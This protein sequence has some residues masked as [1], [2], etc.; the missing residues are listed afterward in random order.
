MNAWNVDYLEEARSDIRSLDNSIAVHVQKSI[1][2]TRLNPLPQTEGGY[3]KPLGNHGGLDLSGLLKVKLKRDGVRIV[4]KLERT[5]TTMK[6]I[7]VG[8][9]SDS[10]VYREAARRKRRHHL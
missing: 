1:A 3:G 5:E 4:Y 2:K 10:E 7:I 9:R 8:V 6:I